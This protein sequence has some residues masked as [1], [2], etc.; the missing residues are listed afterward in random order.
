[1]KPSQVRLNSLQGAA[2]LLQ[3]ISEVLG[4]SVLA[5]RQELNDGSILTHVLRGTYRAHKLEL[6][7]NEEMIVADIEAQYGQFHLLIFN[8]RPWR[9]RYGKPAAFVLANGAEHSMYTLRGELSEDQAK[10]LES[11][12]LSRLLD[13]ISPQ[14]SEQIDISQ[15]LV[16]I[17]LRHPTTERVYSVLNAVVEQMPHEPQK[18]VSLGLDALP[19]GLQPLGP[20][21]AKW[22]IGDDEE[23]SRKLQRS[24]ASTRQ[25]LIDAVIPRLS[26]I[27]AFLD[28]FG[29]NPPDGA[30]AFGSLAQAALEAQSIQATAKKN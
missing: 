26:Q 17:R 6:R 2:A 11:G 7:A 30:C 25:R 8:E 27:D 15:R 20:L 10:L 24:A 18:D 1:M 13:L 16:R 14:E 3:A 9:Y 21:L 29:A 19:D 5:R 28:S 22:A 23:R 4:G 12:A